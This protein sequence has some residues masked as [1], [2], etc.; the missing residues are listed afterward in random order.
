MLEMPDVEKILR[1]KPNA[2][3]KKMMEQIVDAKQMELAIIVVTIIKNNIFL[4]ILLV[5]KICL[6]N[7]M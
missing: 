7:P 4:Q 3:A 6:T 2:L 1:M 5:L